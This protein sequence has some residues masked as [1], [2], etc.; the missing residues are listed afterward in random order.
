MENIANTI[1]DTCDRAYLYVLDSVTDSRPSVSVN[2]HT[3][4]LSEAPNAYLYNL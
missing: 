1:W 3:G 2:S 4:L